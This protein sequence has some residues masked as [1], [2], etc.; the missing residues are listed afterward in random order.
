MEGKKSF[1][2]YCDQIGL[3]EQLPD[4][5]AGQLIKLIFA[6]VNDEDP[7]I[8]DLLLKVAFG[9]IKLQLKRDLKRW[10][11]IRESRSKAGKASAEARKQKA[12]LSTLVE[13]VEQKATNSTV[14]DN[15]TVNVTV[16]DTVNDTKNP[17]S[18]RVDEFTNKIRSFQIILDS[19]ETQ[20]FID[21]WTEHGEKD[22]KAR[23]QKEKVFDIKKRMERWKRSNKQNKN[24]GSR[25][26]DFQR[27][28]DELGRISS[29]P[30]GD[31]Q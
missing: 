29:I 1:L 14:T 3:F 9:P 11:S 31:N 20:K 24:G 28:H 17:L 12:T 4:E 16:N 13:S 23:W 25:K 10:D 26:D 27:T 8:H 7:K 22:R 18:I 6:Y 30:K 19:I 2:L 21:Y 5:K 15:V